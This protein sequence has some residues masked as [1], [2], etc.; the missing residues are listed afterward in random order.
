MNWLHLS[1]DNPYIKE[2]LIST[3]NSVTN[4]F[5]L[6]G[7]EVLFCNHCVNFQILFSNLGN[8]SDSF[9]TH[10]YGDI[11]NWFPLTIIILTFQDIIC[12]LFCT[13]VFKISLKHVADIFNLST[14]FFCILFRVYGIK[15]AYYFSPSP[16][17]QQKVLS[18][19]KL[20]S[21]REI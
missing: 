16:L 15:N 10:L 11:H 4:V 1:L 12:I 7:T 21:K 3:Y 18:Y 9:V 17:S 8:H 6:L 5:M 20:C 14:T 2:C 19:Q 13:T